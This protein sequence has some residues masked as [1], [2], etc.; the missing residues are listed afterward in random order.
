M[1]TYYS[2]IHGISFRV[3]C[4]NYIEGTYP[5]IKHKVS[6]TIYLQHAF[7]NNSTQYNGAVLYFGY[8][9]HTVNI[10]TG[11]AG[12]WELASGTLEYSFSTNNREDSRNIYFSTS[13]KNISASGSQTE[14]ATISIPKIKDVELSS[15]YN[16]ISYKVTLDSNP[17]DFYTIKATLDKASK[18]GTDGRFEGL[19]PNKE[20][21]VNCY[22]RYRGD[23]SVLLENP[24]SKFIKTKKP[25][26][27]KAGKVEVSNV[28]Y[29]SAYISWSGFQIQDGATDYYYQSST[30]DNNW[31]DR[32]KGTGFEVSRLSPNTKYIYYVRI[33][34]NFGTP[35][36]SVKVV[37]KTA[38]PDKPSKGSVAYTDLNPFGATF[39]WSGFQIEE[40]ANS[41]YY[42]YSF[43]GRIWKDL[44]TQ[45]KLVVDD[46]SPETIYTFYIRIVDDFGTP[47][48]Y[49]NVGFVTPADQ[50]KIAYHIVDYQEA[51]LTKDGFEIADKKGNVLLAEIISDTGK[52]SQAK[53]WY[54]DNGVMKKVKK[55]YFN[56]GNDIKVNINYGG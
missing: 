16:S 32:S 40:G 37:F 28:T 43:D 50:A 24:V 2:G 17:Y 46:L 34:D 45:T 23:T 18:I 39:T 26:K 4:S 1:A 49:A 31:I 51:I 44:Q 5:N 10:N 6:Y 20:Y 11:G 52:L 42:Q 9:S 21:E 35:S 25:N 7:Y 27:P 22:V 33:V 19:S 30:D 54:N 53:V 55:I 3:D 29:K 56:N 36:D 8:N 13:F 15:T 12:T 41:Y 38:K 14:S 47:S 48:D